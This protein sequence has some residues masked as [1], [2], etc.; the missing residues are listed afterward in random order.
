[1]KNSIAKLIATVFYVGLIPIA[2]GTFGTIAAIPLFYALSFTPLYLYLA[3]TVLIILISVWAS[4]VAEEIFGK[5]DPGE[6]VADEVCGYLVT[7]ILVPLTL[8]NIFFGFLLFRLFDIAKPYPIRKFERLP[9]GWGIV[10][11]DVMAGV[12]SC[13]TLHILGRWFF[14]A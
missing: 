8:G 6:V 13:I 3:I 7:M 5:T 11:D 9:G 4:G 14:W 2:P 1:M 10:M 12:Y